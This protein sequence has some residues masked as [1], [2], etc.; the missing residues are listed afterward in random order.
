MSGFA[1]VAAVAITAALGLSAVCEAR[2]AEKTIDWK[3]AEQAILRIDNHPVNNWNVFQD[4]KKTTPL[5]LKLAKRFLLIDSRAHKVFEL[6]PTKLKRKDGDLYWDT[7][8]LPDQPLKTTQWTVR[9]VG[10]AYRIR[11]H[12]VADKQTIDLQLPHPIDIRPLY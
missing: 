3:P 7:A 11:V 6:D 1:T 2:A 4:G 8:D 10:L 9:D 12:L 5:L